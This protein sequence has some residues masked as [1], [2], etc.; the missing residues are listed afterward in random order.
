MKYRPIGISG[1]DAPRA[2]GDNTVD[3]SQKKN[4]N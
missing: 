4:R 1:T 2:G 3:T